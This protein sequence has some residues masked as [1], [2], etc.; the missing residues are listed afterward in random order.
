M[1]VANSKRKPTMADVAALVGVSKTAVSAVLGNRGKPKNVGE[2]T[3][4]Q[5]RKVAAELG[6]RANFTARSLATGRTGFI[7]F[8]LASSVSQGF[9]NPYFA[10]FLQGA[11]TECRRRG[12]GLAISCA[13]VNEAGGFIHSN[14]LSQRRIDALIVAGEIDTC[15]YKELMA[16]GIPYLALNAAPAAGVNT[17]GAARQPDVIRF[18]AAKGHRR[19]LMTDNRGSG[20]PGDIL[21]RDV[22]A[23][24]TQLGIEVEFMAPAL[25]QHPNWEPGFGLGR[26]LFE[27]WSAQPEGRRATLIFSNGVLAEFYAE[28]LK[29]GMRCP[30]DVSLLGDRS[31]DNCAFPMFTRISSDHEAAGADAVSLLVETVETGVP[32]DIAACAAKVYPALTIEG[33]TVKELK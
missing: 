25:G 33:Q 18:A 31:L 30:E 21:R 11:E 24:A 4:G 1:T 14:I 28:L 23:A 32:M 19:M 29:A 20:R 16:S 15:V 22:E 27:R 5:I 7:G 3:A 8:M 10:G 12:Y 6:Y 13:P 9:R 2:K 17:L 26:H